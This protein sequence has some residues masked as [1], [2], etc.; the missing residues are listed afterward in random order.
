VNRILKFLSIIA[1]NPRNTTKI[2]TDAKWGLIVYWIENY[3][4]SSP[5]EHIITRLVSHKN[6]FEKKNPPEFL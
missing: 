6:D 5:L 4:I 1:Q 2:P 3:Y